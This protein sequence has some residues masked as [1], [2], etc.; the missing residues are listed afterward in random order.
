M[1]NLVEQTVTPP[2]GRLPLRGLR[3]LDLTDEAVVLAPRLLADLGAEVVRAESA[4]GDRLRRRGPFLDGQP[5]LERSL[6]HLLYNGGKRS[7][8]LALDLSESWEVLDALL[9][10]AEVLIAPLEKT[11][12]AQ[13]F[14]AP[15]RLAAAHPRL[16]VVDV[17]FRADP[18]QSAMTDL[19]GVAAGGLLC[20]NGF[21][22]DPPNLPA[23]KLAY[24]QTSLAAALGAMALV[25]AARRLGRGGRICVNMQEAVMWTTIQT[26]NENYWHWHQR[27][28][29]RT[30][31]A[32]LGKAG[33]RSIFQCKDG[34][35]VS[36]SIHPP[37][38]DRFVAW[39]LEATGDRRLLG[40]EWSEPLHRYQRGDI[41][42]ELIE[43]IAAQL[44]QEE[45]LREGQ[46]RG[47]LIGPVNSVAEIAKDEHL[48][49][50]GLFQ[51]VPHPQFARALTMLRPPFFSTAYEVEM[52]PAP[53]LGQDSRA[54]L[55]E[56]LGYDAERLNALLARG[57]ISDGTG[58]CA[59]AG[60]V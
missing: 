19:I 31:A 36:F 59:A 51:A 24:K 60:E 55:S 39:V 21:S 15:E 1:A 53:A 8:A 20:L 29:G 42:T 52:R 18:T 26:A 38:W 40:D 44:S 47:V 46:R 6:A 12:L 57:I 32:G 9:D 50:R 11:A 54:L 33:S 27:S 5:G 43:R 25:L 3:I 58:M 4:S 17:A 30:G 56:W 2:A 7:L 35:W 49:Q 16:N 41:V 28:P 14:F 45:M 22:E 34:R 10:C 23:G 37:Y 48:L 13:R